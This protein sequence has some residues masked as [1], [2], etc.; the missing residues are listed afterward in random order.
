VR[1]LDF[2]ALITAYG[3]IRARGSG[4]HEIYRR[5]DVVEILNIQN[6]N[7]KAKSYQIKQFLSLIEK[8]NLKMEDE[9]NVQL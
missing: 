7:G 4:S 9:T 5:Q 2:V 1:Y 8:Y 6:D 3:F